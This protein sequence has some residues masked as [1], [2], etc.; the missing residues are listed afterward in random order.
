MLIEIIL[1]GLI[2]NYAPLY[3]V[4]L[5]MPVCLSFSSYTV[6]IR[7]LVFLYKLKLFILKI[8]QKWYLGIKIVGLEKD[9]KKIKNNLMSL[10]YEC[11]SVRPFENFVTNM[12]SLCIFDLWI[13]F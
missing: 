7:G 10:W 1:Q 11:L 2:C 12:E 9:Q 4:Y 8:G 6:Y 13:H 5:D 3:G